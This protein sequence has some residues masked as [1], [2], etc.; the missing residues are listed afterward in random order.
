[1]ESTHGAGKSQDVCWRTGGK[2]TSQIT[3][4]AE[5]SINPIACKCPSKKKII[6][7]TL[8][9]INNGTMFNFF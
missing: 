6:L 1:M 7:L 8:A 3:P 2:L 4:A 9:D 5:K